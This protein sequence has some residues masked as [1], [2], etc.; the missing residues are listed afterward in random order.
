MPHRVHAAVNGVEPA[1]LDPSLDRP[2]ADPRSEQ[3]T[4]AHHPMLPPSERRNDAV[5]AKVE[6]FAPYAVVKFSTLAHA[7]DDADENA[8][9]L[10]P[11]VSK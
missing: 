8:T 10:A 1:R 2:G 3:L 6:N 4:P 9:E 5:G 11:S 7:P